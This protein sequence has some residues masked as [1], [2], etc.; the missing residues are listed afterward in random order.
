MG[1][2]NCGME[3]RRRGPRGTQCNCRQS[4]HLTRAERS[5]SRAALVEENLDSNF[6][7]RR[8]SNGQ[9]RRPRTGRHEGVLDSAA[10]PFVD[11]RGTKGGLGGRG[12]TRLRRS[13]WF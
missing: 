12:V 11:Q 8:K 7:V 10:N 1:L 3:V 13:G 9:W 2:D 6:T 5:E 4:G